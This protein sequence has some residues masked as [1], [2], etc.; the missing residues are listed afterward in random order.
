[1]FKHGRSHRVFTDGFFSDDGLDFETR[2]ALGQS[3]YGGSDV[4]EVLATI[5]RVTNETSWFREWSATATRLQEQAD[6]DLRSRRHASAASAYL[7]AS[8]YWA[9]AMGGLLGEKDTEVLSSTFKSH[10]VCWDGFIDAAQGRHQPVQVPYE[11]TTL[12]GWLLR[13]D[14]SG[15]RRPTFVMTNGSD[16]PISSLWG[17]GAAEALAR[18]WNAFVYDGPGQQT[19]LFDQGMPFRHDWEA[20]FTPVVDTLVA[21]DDVDADRLTAYGISQAG[22]WLP[23]ALAFEHRIKAAVADPGVVDVST[24]WTGHLPK[25]M[26]QMLDEGDRVSFNRDLGYATKIPALRRQLQFRARPFQRD[27]WFDVFTDVRRYRLDEV[28]GN[29]STPL[30]ICDP[31]DEQFWPGQSERLSALVPHSHLQRFTAAEGANFHCQ[32]MAR[33]LTHTRMFDWLEAQ[34]G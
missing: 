5:A 26:V 6:E 32:P 22:Y 8:G 18:G 4:G 1:M 27:S 31:E 34:L 10:R 21:R 2:L 13:P 14:D 20:V 11:G 17:T 29:I 9:Q 15:R 19:M 25:S 7:R 28:A 23:R 12:P 33:L 30:F 24:A 3:V 16:G